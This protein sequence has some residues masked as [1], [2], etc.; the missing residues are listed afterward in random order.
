MSSLITRQHLLS[1]TLA[2][3][4]RVQ[5]DRSRD[6]NNQPDGGGNNH[7]LAAS[8]PAN[9]CFVLF[10]GE[11]YCRIR[12][13]SGGSLACELDVRA[14]CG[15]PNRRITVHAVTPVRRYSCAALCTDVSFL[16]LTRH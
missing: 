14:R 6:N 2:F 12:P 11:D 16:F 15:C 1:F 5:S 13:V 4:N 3:A 10:R 7:S 9:Y 8:R